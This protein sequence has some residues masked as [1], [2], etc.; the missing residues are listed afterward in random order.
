MRQD[1]FLLQAI[2]QL[3]RTSRVLR[4][5]SLSRLKQERGSQKKKISFCVIGNML[6]ENSFRIPIS[7]LMFHKNYVKYFL[8]ILFYALVFLHK[9]KLMIKH[10]YNYFVK[11]IY[12]YGHF[13]INFLMLIN[14]EVFIPQT[15]TSSVFYF[16]IFVAFLILYLVNRFYFLLYKTFPLEISSDN[17]KLICE[18]FIFNKKRKETVYFKDIVSLSGGIFDGRLNGMM[19]I[20]DKNNLSIAF[21]HRIS[22]SSN[23]IA[24]I[25]SKVDKKIYDSAIE[26]LSKFGVRLSTK[27]QKG[28]KN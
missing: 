19:K 27:K 28:K 18:K 17:E 22:E 5:T 4:L 7:N 1:L 6:S 16:P 20:T 10:H 3:K 12:R 26:N 13:F 25:L 9:R 8:N 11:L 14:I 24:K 21:S 2:L 23:L 15:K